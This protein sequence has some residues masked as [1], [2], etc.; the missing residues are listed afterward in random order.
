MY[1]HSGEKLTEI[2][3]FCLRLINSLRSLLST[4]KYFLSSPHRLN[5]CTVTREWVKV[6]VKVQNLLWRVS[7]GKTIS[8]DLDR[9]FRKTLLFWEVAKVKIQIEIIKVF[10]LSAED[11]KRNL[12]SLTL[13]VEIYSTGEHN[14]KR[15]APEVGTSNDVAV[16]R[17][18]W[19]WEKMGQSKRTWPLS[20]PKRPVER[21]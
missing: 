1:W 8:G 6:F 2:H 18:H 12:Y 7:H 15:E 4:Q 10:S 3:F 21:F 20:L 11:R 16:D 17:Q 19:I 13:T 5:T 9:S 14:R